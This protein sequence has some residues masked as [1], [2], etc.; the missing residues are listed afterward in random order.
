[1]IYSGTNKVGT[2]YSGADK[3]DK[4]YK[5][6]E[7]VYS[8]A[9]ATPDRVFDPN[10][11]A[12]T[13]DTTLGTKGG[14]NIMKLKATARNYYSAID[15]GDGKVDKSTDSSDSLYQH[16]YSVSG[17][18]TIQFYDTVSRTN[19]RDYLEYSEKIIELNN[20]AVNNTGA[21]RY[22]FGGCINMEA[23]YKKTPKIV[24]TGNIFANCHKFNGPINFVD[25]GSSTSMNDMFLNCYTFNQPL[26]VNLTGLNSM[27]SMFKNCTSLKQ[28][29]AG[30]RW[31]R[32]NQPQFYASDF[33]TGCDINEPGTTTNYDE[34][35][36]DWAN[37]GNPG[38]TR[39]N[40]SFGNSKYSSV[41]KVGR[42]ILIS[43]GW[44]ITDGGMI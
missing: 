16:T 32:G 28:S 12:I 8:S 13:I 34:T 37:S 2:I 15:W 43:K 23:K 41:G 4:I 39:N 25:D 17:I 44:I 5:G 6:E 21:Y 9:P 3:V 10:K 31:K 7:L 38:P 22:S 11:F 27:N 18:Y 42:D 40:I 33:L 26:T 29:L 35:L 30:W 19:F 36:L 1:M 20:F 14:D 24:A